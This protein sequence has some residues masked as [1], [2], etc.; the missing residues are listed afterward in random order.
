MSRSR[1]RP[2]AP[3][4]KV[5][6]AFGRRSPAP[7]GAHDGGAIALGPRTGLRATCAR[8]APITAISASRPTASEFAGPLAVGVF[9]IRV[10][11]GSRRALAFESPTCSNSWA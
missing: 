8:F 4:I 11:Y 7:L 10:A 5:A 3:N 9:A 1:H 6:A 2:R